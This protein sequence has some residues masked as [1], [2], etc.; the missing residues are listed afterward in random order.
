MQNERNMYGVEPSIDEQ[1]R[2]LPALTAHRVWKQAGTP[3][4]TAI[5]EAAGVGYKG[6]TLVRI[7]KKN[8]SYASAR[9]LQYG[10]FMALGVVVN[11]DTLCNAINYREHEEEIERRAFEAAK[12]S[13]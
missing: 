9:C 6:F 10:I 3:V 4:M 2:A 1:M 8:L 12:V 11:L 13:A 7:G 5:C